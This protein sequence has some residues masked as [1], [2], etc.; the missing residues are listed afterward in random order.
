MNEDVKRIYK[1]VCEFEEFEKIVRPL[2]E[3]LGH[4]Y[5]SHQFRNLREW[6]E[7]LWPEVKGESD[8]N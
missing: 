8:G 4:P 3:T 7:H 5:C 1:M 2:P 6:I